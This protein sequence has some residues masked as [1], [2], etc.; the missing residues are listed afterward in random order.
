LGKAQI[1]LASPNRRRLYAVHPISALA[2]V[3]VRKEAR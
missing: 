1:A 3:K 2:M